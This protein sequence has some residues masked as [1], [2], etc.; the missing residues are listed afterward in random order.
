MH[1][2]YNGPA[3]TLALHLMSISS[4]CWQRWSYS[5][6][7][8][9]FIWTTKVH[10]NC[11]KCIMYKF[12]LSVSSNTHNKPTYFHW[13]ICIFVAISF[14]WFWRGIS[15]LDGPDVK[16]AFQQTCYV[17]LYLYQLSI[18]ISL[19]TSCSISLFTSC[20]ISTG[21]DLKGSILLTIQTYNYAS[22]RRALRFWCFKFKSGSKNLNE[23]F[24]TLNR[25]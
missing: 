1:K 2:F 25:G 7:C 24:V 23:C 5:N 6:L 16:L 3:I 4:K 11:K 13:N 10:Q 19:F 21:A 18:S 17:Q 9:D 8:F 14:V 20:S 22:S 12:C 15:S